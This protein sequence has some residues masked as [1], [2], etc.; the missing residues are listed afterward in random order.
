[1]MSTDSLDKILEQGSDSANSSSLLL[2][3][4]RDRDG[5]D[6]IGGSAPPQRHRSNRN[7]I[8]RVGFSNDPDSPVDV[9]DE[10]AVVVVSKVVGTKE[11]EA[12]ATKDINQEVGGEKGVDPS[13]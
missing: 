12:T 4:K 13:I 5:G 10:D 1:M 7:T 11:A 2:R 6:D 8:I 3:R 9:I